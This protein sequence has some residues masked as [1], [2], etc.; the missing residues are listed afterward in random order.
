M[1]LTSRQAHRAGAGQPLPLPQVGDRASVYS[2]QGRICKV[3]PVH[4]DSTGR[5]VRYY[6]RP[7]RADWPGGTISVRR[8]IEPGRMQS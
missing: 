6:V 8:Y 3:E 5:Y 2:E 1:N 7:C 4:A